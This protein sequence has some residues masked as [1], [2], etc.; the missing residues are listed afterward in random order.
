MTKK[1]AQVKGILRALKDSD[2]K[3]CT[4]TVE[5]DLKL[6]AGYL[7]KIKDGRKEPSDQ[8]VE[9]LVAYRDKKLSK[10]VKPKEVVKKKVIVKVTAPKKISVVTPIVPAPSKKKPELSAYMQTRQRM[11]GVK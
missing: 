4:S 2:L 1:Q 9:N 3:I 5:G 11:K 6:S 7:W 10:T 8:L